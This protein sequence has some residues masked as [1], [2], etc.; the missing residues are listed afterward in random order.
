MSV[1]ILDH[2]A[3]QPDI[4]SLFEMFYMERDSDDAQRLI[5]LTD[6]ARQIGRPKVMYREASIDARGND[7]IIAEDIKLTSHM[8]RMNLESTHKIYPYILTCGRELADWAASLDDM[9]EQFW[10]DKV[11]E[12][13]LEA[14]TTAFET[15]LKVH[16]NL[17]STS[18]MNPG[19]L[20]NWPISQQEKLFDILGDPYD[21][22]G[23]ELTDSYLM[24]PIKSL[25]G[26]RFYS[27]VE[28]VNCQFC[29]R[30]NCPN[31]RME[32]DHSAYEKRYMK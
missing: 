12:I 20:E 19:S 11:M 15:H 7:Y 24:L 5:E 28:F 4:N 14:A 10:M 23:V 27:D 22:I 6:M 16:Y 3:F 17:C 26:I 30:K 29:N 13:A 31:R 21:K 8:L 9:L 18:N 2:I 32:Y 25:C 1:N